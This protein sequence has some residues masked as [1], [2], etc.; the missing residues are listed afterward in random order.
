MTKLILSAIVAF[1]GLAYALW[2]R[3][4]TT[5]RVVRKL[6]EEIEVLKIEEDKA[7]T[8]RDYVKYNRLNLKRMSINKRISRYTNKRHR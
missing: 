1:L 8:N 6:L 4:G 7:L 5:E 3:Y 2:R